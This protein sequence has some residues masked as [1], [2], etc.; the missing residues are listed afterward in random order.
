M[1]FVS[2]HGS[3]GGPADFSSLEKVLP[4]NYRH[5]DRYLPSEEEGELSSEN[6]EVLIG[7]SWGAR[8]LFKYY[9]QNREKVVAIILISPYMFHA[10]TSPMKK[11]ILK[12]VWPG[13]L[14]ISKLA[15]KAIDSF[16]TESSCPQRPSE[17]YLDFKKYLA[18]VDVLKASLLEKD[19]FSPLMLKNMNVSKKVLIL[20]GKEDKTSLFQSQITPVLEAVEESRLV[21]L[22]DAGHALPWTSSSEIIEPIQQFLKSI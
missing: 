10:Q 8:E 15:S 14:I 19:A 7:Y 6:R 11:I 17:S 4:G 13:N 21:E 5:I 9:E 12:T 18:R 1:N 2:F 3:P 22:E 20:W 16:V